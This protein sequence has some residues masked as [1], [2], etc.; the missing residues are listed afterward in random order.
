MSALSHTRA[1]ALKSGLREVLNELQILDSDAKSFR[2]SSS[3]PLNYPA[4]R[5]TSWMLVSTNLIYG[6]RRLSIGCFG[7]CK[8]ILYRSTRHL[9]LTVLPLGHA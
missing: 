1:A 8:T 5:S 4:P 7:I 2:D 6:G 3:C 9:F